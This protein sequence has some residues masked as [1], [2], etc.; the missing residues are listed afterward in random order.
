[1]SKAA[2]AIACHPDD[3]E[4]GMAGTLIKLKEAGYEIHYM[5]IANGSLGT[6]QYD[7]KTIVAMRREEAMNAAKL[8]GAHYH[9][10]ICDDLEVYYCHDLF[11]KV[12]PEIRDV[13]PE[14]VLTHGP[15]DY[16]EDHVNAGRI[17]TTAAFCR[18]MT[19]CKCSRP[20]K[21]VDTPVAVYHSA[22]HSLTDT[23]R[24][25]V[26]PGMYVNIE[27]TVQTKKDMLC[28][29]RSQKDWLDISQGNDAY[30]DDMESRARYYG[31]LS[32]RYTFAEGWIRHNHLGFCGPDFNPMLEAL[33]EN[34]FVNQKFEDSLKLEN[35][36]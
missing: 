13:D 6:N 24:R 29:H 20:A 22:P 18:G 16:M 23:L 15:Y 33:G 5:N 27:T 2:F 12:V 10:S 4:F 3:I 21:A 8:I 14:I 19:N 34:C 36:L 11:A 7:Y 35:Y 32:G 17:A 26:I 28:C 31:K 25:P 9:E 1:M 30:L